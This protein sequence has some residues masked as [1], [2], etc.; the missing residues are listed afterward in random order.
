MRLG[1]LMSDRA[2]FDLVLHEHR[3]FAVT[4]PLPRVTH[5]IPSLRGP[6]AN[7]ENR[8]FGASMAPWLARW[9]LQHTPLSQF[10]STTSPLHASS[11]SFTCPHP[12][13]VVPDLPRTCTDVPS[14]NTPWY[15][16]R[17]IVS[18]YMNSSYELCFGLERQTVEVDDVPFSR[19]DAL[20]CMDASFLSFKWV[21]EGT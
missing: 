15:T 12:L 4:P 10:P 17:T 18:G 9:S 16:I 2:F 3:F 14:S 6:A 8:G 21:A 19:K 5:I 1:R 20:H 11:A 13:D 7:V